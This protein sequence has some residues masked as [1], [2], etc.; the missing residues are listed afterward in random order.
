MEFH[1]RGLFH[2]YEVT[3]RLVPAKA[4][5]GVVFRRT[6]LTEAPD[7]PA[8][9][10]YLAKEPRRTVL[11]SAVGVRVE[12]VEHL[13]SALTAMQVDNCLV[14]INAP[15][16]PS[17][18]GS[19][20]VFCDGILDAG[21][22]SQEPAAAYFAVDNVQSVQSSDRKQS[23]VARPYLFRCAAITYHLD[24]G[25]GS[26]LPPQC[27]SVEITPEFFYENIAAARTFVLE[28]EIGA[29]RQL[30]YGRHLTAKDI[31]VVGPHGIIDN[32]LRWPDEGVRHKILDCLGDLAL[33]G[34]PFMG[35]VT[36]CRSG[37]HLN[38]ELARSFQKSMN[39][40]GSVERSVAA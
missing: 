26:I 5:T 16:V 11:E 17:F 31:V 23:L 3:A 27:L 10:E 28:Q 7:I 19:S 12:T 18:D 24:Y 8:R 38:H 25:R 22:E 29:L 39:A 20:L 13:M 9:C 35:H 37:H 36:A 15:E 34:R 6:D 40:F 4:D 1:G 21:L 32:Q 2:G 14:E 30:G 33:C